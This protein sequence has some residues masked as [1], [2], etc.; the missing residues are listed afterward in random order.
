MTHQH[1]SIDSQQR[2]KL[3][4][5]VDVKPTKA[6]LV[7]LS[8][9]PISKHL[10]PT[11]KTTIAS[12]RKRKLILVTSNDDEE[13]PLVS[14]IKRKALAKEPHDAKPTNPI[15]LTTILKDLK[16]TPLDAL[17]LGFST[18]P[19]DNI[20]SKFIKGSFGLKI[21]HF[22]LHSLVIKLG[23]KIMIQ[24]D[25]IC[26]RLPMIDNNKYKESQVRSLATLLPCNSELSKERLDEVKVNKKLSRLDRVD[27]IGPTSWATSK[28]SRLLFGIGSIL[29]S[30][31]RLHQSKIQAHLVAKRRLLG[32]VNTL[33]SDSSPQYL[34]IGGGTLQLLWRLSQ[35]VDPQ[36]IMNTLHFLVSY[37]KSYLELQTSKL[38]NLGGS[39]KL[40][41]RYT[42]SLFLGLVSKYMTRSNPDKLH[43][44]DSE[45]DRTFH[46]LLRSL[47]SS[48]IVN[49]SSHKSNVFA[50]DF[51]ILIFNIVDF[52]FNIANSNSDFGVDTS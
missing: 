41:Q 36:A 29:I 13:V 37:S 30:E 19:E 39:R 49:S 33:L 16:F 40:R 51:G 4:E 22:T 43:A 25:R 8:K 14:R 12:V 11:T 50:S 10:A 47:R 9:K 31:G 32:R 20:M 5:P 48:E 42:N 6:E 52:D 45:I 17:T 21:H 34:A 44:C 2:M 1:L 15:V 23:T 24:L 27:S 38:D 18:N 46:K 35:E 3:I 7:A 28:Q 26:L